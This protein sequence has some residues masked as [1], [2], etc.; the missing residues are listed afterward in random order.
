MLTDAK[1]DYVAT[2]TS[3]LAIRR[4]RYALTKVLVIGVVSLGIFVF[5][6]TQVSPTQLW[7]TLHGMPAVSLGLA[8]VTYVAIGT[9][10]ARRLQ[11]LFSP[12]PPGYFDALGTAWIHTM[13]IYL[14]PARAGEL[15]LPLLFRR[16]ASL[17]RGIVAMGW[18]RVLD[19]V[20]LAVIVPVIL[21]VIP[22][23][24][25]STP[26]PVLV[27][28]VVVLTIGLTVTMAAERVVQVWL[29]IMQ[30]LATSPSPRLQRVGARGVSVCHSFLESLRHIGPK[31]GIYWALLALSILQWLAGFLY[32][33][34]LLYGAGISLDPPQVVLVSAVASLLL[35]V[36]IQGIAGV[37]S[38]EGIWVFSL[39]LVGVS[40]APAILASLIIHMLTLCIAVGL[41]LL[42]LAYRTWRGWGVG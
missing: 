27:A 12:D 35:A 22:R 14:L 2:V 32:Y 13:L 17:S 16:N 36:P 4:D 38:Y 41:G 5:L 1:R 23:Q 24:D 9:T 3:L 20:A 10:K 8:C 40:T 21:L 29:K 25:Q 33:G 7:N 26:V 6:L 31:S 15:S 19:L 42:G 18:Y 28:E 34:A 37:G 30:R 39:A 11:L